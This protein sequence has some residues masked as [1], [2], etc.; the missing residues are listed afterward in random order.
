MLTSFDRKNISR[1]NTPFIHFQVKKTFT[2]CFAWLW[3]FFSGSLIAPAMPL[4]HAEVAGPGWA[5]IKGQAVTPEQ[6]RA[7]YSQKRSE[8]ASATTALPLAAGVA[9]AL[10][11]EIIELARGLHHDPKLIFEYVRN[12]VDY[13]PYF[14]SL[15][16][17][18]MTYFDGA[19]ND[20][21][22]ASLMIALLRE[23]GYQA[24]YV[25]GRMLI[26]FYGGNNNQDMLHWLSVDGNAGLILQVLYNGGIPADMYG[27]FC[28][29]ERVW[30]SAVIDGNT[31][32]FDPAFKTYETTAGIDLSTAMGYNRS[33]LLSAAG[34]TLGAD[35]IAG[36]NEAGLNNM[37]TAYSGNLLTFIRNNYPN[38]SMEEITGG[39][40]I[41]P[42]YLDEL[43]TSPGFTIYSQETP[44]DEIPEE[45]RHTVTIRHGGINLTKDIASLGGKRL[46]LSYQ[47]TAGSAAAALAADSPV[48]LTTADSKSPA[49][50][51][52]APSSVETGRPADLILSPGM[53]IT[54]P[55]IEGGMVSALG[56]STQNFGRIYPASVGTSSTSATW[57]PSAPSNNNVT[58]QLIVG[59]TKNPQS[60]YAITA[61]S[62]T[63]NLAPGQGVNVTVRF[64][65]SG[66]SAGTKTG[67]MRFLWKYNGDVI[68]TNYI[69]LTGVVANA[70]D[71]SLNGINFGQSILNEPRTATATLTNSGSK[72]LSLTSNIVLSTGNTGRFQITSNYGTGTL[73]PGTARN[74]GVKYKANA[75]GSHATGMAL[76]FTYDQLPYTWTYSNVL[77]GS[78]HYA[79]D[80]TGSY[81][82]PAWQTYI[83]NSKSGNCILKN[84]GSLN[85][86]VTS[87]EITGTNPARFE[88]TGNTSPGTLSSG[89]E[90]D[91]E[92]EYKG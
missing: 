49:V 13:V 74:M 57:G 9:E 51:P 32:V 39:R 60:A 7:Y 61:G 80:L 20:F 35:Y 76:A 48:R 43:P 28:R 53:Q 66:Q 27:S 24:Q 69:N 46:S 77:A 15:K 92:V 12:H 58:I 18:A 41:V 63:H 68:G 50:L 55:D 19:G 81:N 5:D 78:T 23:S 14:G 26:P 59:L 73:A 54:G 25:Y 79:P 90:R 11:P 52:A 2:L 82:P 16:G 30:V 33:S 89:Q 21:D 62:G 65:N 37:L 31:C 47:D 4:A 40:E 75:R 67:Q 8:K 45:Y 3:L 17:A 64:S 91:I 84:S 6:A 29:M 72:S 22:Q 44:W 34:G 42:E 71:I 87:L 88:L 56:T 85:L 10:S 83:G 70:P 38:A 86:S 1:K 36:M